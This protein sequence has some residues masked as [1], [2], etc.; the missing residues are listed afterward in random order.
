[1]S[2]LKSFVKSSIIKLLE[3]KSS[4]RYIADYKECIALHPELAEPAEGEIEW[5]EKWRKYDKKVSPLSYRIFSRY[6][7]PDINI[8][9]MEICV[10]V[11]EPVLTPGYLAPFYND[12]NSFGLLY[13]KDDMPATYVRNIRGAYYDEEYNAIKGDLVDYIGSDEVIVKP[14]TES[15]GR[16]VALFTK[17]NGVFSDKKGNILTKALLDKEYRADFVIQERF[18]QSDF[19]A[20]FNPSSVNTIRI[21]TYKDPQSG[22]VHYLRG[23]VRIGGIGS[24]VDNAHSGGRFIGIDDNG[25][26]D[27]YVCD[28]VGNISSIH[29]PVDFSKQTFTIPNYEQVKSF[30]LK[31]SK[32]FVHH[33]LFALDIVL[34][35]NNRPKMLEVNIQGFSAWL[36][37]F[38]SG[39]AFR[40]YTDSVMN[41]CSKEISKHD[42]KVVRF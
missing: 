19:M 40:E 23:I 16:G 30:A 26:F 37:Q 7:G 10:N 5:L 15:S 24:I 41:Y 17:Q 2:K 14:A 21:S 11:I 28:Q 33:N 34:D 39:S 20:Q 42:I 35:Q 36:F 31:I 27:G 9:P 25:V 1:M 22:E 3:D 38:T 12:K 4:K 8:L 32:R 18:V 6:I 13:D 29:G